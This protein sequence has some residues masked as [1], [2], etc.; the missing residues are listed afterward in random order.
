MIARGDKPAVKLVPVEGKPKR[1][2]GTLKGKIHL[3]DGFFDPLPE[4]E[5]RRWEGRGH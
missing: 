5:L 1:V 2:A 4:D 3:D